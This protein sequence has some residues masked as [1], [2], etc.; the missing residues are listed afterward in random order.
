M[1]TLPVD[2]RCEAAHFTAASTASCSR[3]P[4]QSLQPDEPPKPGRSTIT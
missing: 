1:P 3:L 2:Q 4:P